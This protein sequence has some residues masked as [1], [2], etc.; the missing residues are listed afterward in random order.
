MRRLRG[1]RRMWWKLGEGCS[2]H[3]ISYPYL[4]HFPL[5]HS[6]YL[7]HIPLS[8]NTSFYI[9][10]TPLPPPCFPTF[11]QTPTSPAAPNLHHIEGCG[12][13]RGTMWKY[14]DVPEVRGYG[15]N[16]RMWPS[17]H[18]PTYVRSSSLHHVPLSPTL[19]CIS[20]ILTTPS[21]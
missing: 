16:R 12:G 8:P 2:L 7:H 18:P 3:H 14:R 15:G 13:G 20:T 11:S 9:H 17:S 6:L 21:T 1:G 4:S 5:P 19:P 10:H